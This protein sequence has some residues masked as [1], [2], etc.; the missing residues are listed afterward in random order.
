MA[1]DKPYR[2]TIPFEDAIHCAYLELIEKHHEILQQLRIRRD[3][4]GLLGGILA[5]AILHKAQR[6]VD[7]QGALIADFDDYRHAW[8]AFNTGLSAIY[9][10]H[11]RKEIIAVAKAAEQMGAELYDEKA[12]LTGSDSRASSI[13][14]T[15]AEMRQALGVGSKSTADRRLEEAVDQGVLKQD[16]NRPYR[17]RT[18]PRAY[19]LLK[20]SKALESGEGAN[21]FPLPEDVEKFL[22]EGGESDG[23]RHAVHAV[24]AP[25]DE[26]G[27]CPPCTPCLFPSQDPHPQ[28][29]FSSDSEQSDLGP[30]VEEGEL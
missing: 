15:V 28:E 6:Q 24:H 8:L 30:V 25:P 9:G 1:L 13:D 16:L 11:V 5:S 27:A 19:W 23:N 7:A 14:I 22:E 10:V 29:T 21:V 4:S 2:V 3:I 26:D 18:T 17:G 12:E 20:T